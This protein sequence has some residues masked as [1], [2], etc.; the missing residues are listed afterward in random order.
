[1]FSKLSNKATDFLVKNKTIKIEDAEIYRYGVQQ[2][3]I[4][5]VNLITTFAIAIILNEIW[6]CVLFMAVYV[7]LRQYAG[8]YH[9][10]TPLRCYIFSN[11]LIFA[12]LL[13]IKIL[14]LGVFIC[15]CLSLASGV[16]IYILSPVE[17]AH[18]PLDDK[19]KIVYQRRARTI[20]IVVVLL[21][22]LFSIVHFDRA[23]MC[24]SL[25]LFALAVFMVAGKLSTE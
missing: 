12:V 23:V 8:G 24:I 18:K 15:G 25:A 1:M 17:S 20:L 21:Q 3:L 10:K 6:Q 14:S 7:P 5:I 16:L 4:L 2:G 11:A 19:E 13:I 22:I 9:A